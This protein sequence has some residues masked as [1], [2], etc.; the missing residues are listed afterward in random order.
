MA[1]IWTL[2]GSLLVAV[3]IVASSATHALG[4]TVESDQPLWGGQWRTATRLVGEVVCTGCSLYEVQVGRPGTW[5]MLHQLTHRLGRVVI[6]VR[7]ING[8][9][10]WHI[11]DLYPEIAVYCRDD[12]FQQL[13]AEETLF[14]DV[15]IFGLLSDTQMLEIV[16]V[17]VLPTTMLTKGR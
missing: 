8:S 6:Q 9:Q 5:Q 4:Q 15:E 14:K 3:L 1:A 2:L 16:T 17:N 12:L 10:I 13:T 7:S 11:G